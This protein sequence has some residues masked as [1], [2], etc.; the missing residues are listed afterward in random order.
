MT[1]PEPS[2]MPEPQ[3]VLRRRHVAT[4]L[5]RLLAL[6]SFGLAI[7]GALLP[8]LP[9]VP[10]LLVAAWAASRGWPQFEAWLIRHPRFGPPVLRWRERGAVSRA[11]KWLA[12]VMMA[13]SALLLQ[14]LAQI[15]LAVRVGV[16]LFL[17]GM[18]IWLWRRPE[19]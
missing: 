7:L 10:F 3:R 1:E 6:L 19:E 12:S 9:T 18:A 16:P 5:W 2:G 4:L 8:V 11:A 17:L 15:P 13:A 14:F